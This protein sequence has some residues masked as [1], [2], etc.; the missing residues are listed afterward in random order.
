MHTAS[1]PAGAAHS[2][3][4]SLLHAERRRVSSF[5]IIITTAIF[6]SVLI[7]YHHPY[8]LLLY[9][10][11]LSSL[12]IAVQKEESFKTVSHLLDNS[13]SSLPSILI[14]YHHPY[15][16]LLYYYRLSFLS[17]TVSP[18]FCSA[19]RKEENL[20]TVYPLGL[21]CITIAIFFSVPIPYVTHGIFYCII[22]AHRYYLAL[23]SPSFVPLFTRRV[24]R[25]FFPLDYSAPPLP[26][27]LITYHHPHHLLLYHY[28]YYLSLS[29]LSLAPP[30]TRRGALRPCLPLHNSASH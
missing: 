21:F 1:I 7:P 15:H 13:A 19:I 29:P 9:Y 6:C 10:C 16:L 24:L 8:H 3:K 23:S 22:I 26:S 30:F 12:S 17:I 5:I 28:R 14:A 4:A 25:S 11:S 18:F 2:R 27:I 20:E